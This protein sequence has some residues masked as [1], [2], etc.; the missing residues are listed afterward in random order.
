[1]AGKLEVAKVSQGV[2]CSQVSSFK[3]VNVTQQ[4]NIRSLQAE[5]FE[6]KVKYGQLV[7]DSNSRKGILQAQVWGL[8]VGLESCLIVGRMLLLTRVA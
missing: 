8:E 5:A 6:V 2:F 3:E 7:V 1:M 4:E